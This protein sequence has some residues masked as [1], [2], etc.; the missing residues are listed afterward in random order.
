MTKALA[1]DTTSDF[2]SLAVL[3]GLNPVAGY[4]ERTGTAMTASVF[5]EIDRLL[6]GA[7]LKAE[8]LEVIIIATG[9]GSFT[10][11][12]I[13]LAIAKTF[14]Q[15]IGCP[16]IGVDTLRILA[17]QSKP[18]PGGVVHALLNC[19]RDEVYHAPYRWGAEGLEAMGEITI[20]NLPDLAGIIGDEPVV[21]RRFDPARPKQEELWAGLV[22]A[23]MDHPSP[24]GSLLLR[25]GLALYR[26]QP[27][28]PYPPAVPIYLKSEAFRKWKP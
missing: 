8:E 15:V 19:I 27:E 17:A 24:D 26:K 3:Q 9:P 16:L 23:R 18:E 14:S 2:L 6:Q 11:T 28:G 10:G 5:D 22:M 12:R 21:L 25:E 4:Y 1:I 20:N 7:G 13:G